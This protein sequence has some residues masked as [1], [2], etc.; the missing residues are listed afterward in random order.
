MARRAVGGMM[1]L[2]VIV[3]T[4]PVPA[5]GAT[6]PVASRGCVTPAPG[7]ARSVIRTVSFF[8]GTEDVFGVEAGFSFSLMDQIFW[9]IM[10]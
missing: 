4:L 2:V 6:G 1:E 5:P 7:R 3:G 9:R 8:K 10:P